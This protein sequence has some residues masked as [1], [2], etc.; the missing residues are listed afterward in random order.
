M[1]Y[2]QLGPDSGDT[3]APRRWTPEDEDPLYEARARAAAIRS[4]NKKFVE[5]MEEAR[6][7]LSSHVVIVTCPKCNGTGGTPTRW[8][9]MDGQRKEI[10]AEICHYCKGQKTVHARTEPR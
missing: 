8:V 1:P 9:M 2:E 3:Q 10:P 7:E 5:S 6:V 4:H